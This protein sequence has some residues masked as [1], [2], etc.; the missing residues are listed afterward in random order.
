MVC[1]VAIGLVT[2]CEGFAMI[3]E[4]LDMRTPATDH[5]FHLSPEVSIHIYKIP[6]GNLGRV[7]EKVARLNKRALK[8]GLVPIVLN[9]HG[10]EEKVTRHEITGAERRT[11]L[12]LL[13]IQGETPTLAGW[14]FL[15]TLQH[16][17]DDQGAPMNLVRAVPGSEGL[18]NDYRAVAQKCDHCQVS[19]RRIDTYVVRHAESGDIK[20][21]GSSC[22]VDFIGTEDPTTVLARFTYLLSLAGILESE[23]S[24]SSGDRRD[25]S[26]SLED[27]LGCVCACAREHGFTTRK[28]A[29]DSQGKV[30]TASQAMSVLFPAP[31][32]TN[33]RCYCGN[34]DP[35][36]VQVSAD[37]QA[38]A[39][40][41]LAWARETL[42][43]R[44]QLND[45]L[46]NLSVVSSLESIDHKSAGI[47]ASLI[48]C[49]AREMEKAIIAKRERVTQA[50]SQYVGQVKDKVTLTAQLIGLRSF[51]TRYGDCHMHRFL[52]GSGNVLT[53]FA[54]KSQH[55]QVGSTYKVIGTVKK[56]E[57]YQGIKQTV[58]TRVKLEVIEVNQ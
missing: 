55:A 29:R 13:S 52:D 41:A 43:D 49:Y 33:E 3:E 47:A 8:L 46:Y 34:R 23:E 19:R 36:H 51:E 24:Y 40:A 9:S 22:L 56:H 44:N 7:N 53:W 12:H 45:Y 5:T 10:I 37:D 25:Y 32:T 14:Q 58:L 26:F 57:S 39:L 21:V 6:A 17:T 4:C 27:Y 54:S 15:A 30:A 50:N 28:E 1:G 18:L 16:L 35:R 11:T 42:T 2:D 38:N 31:K 48:P 20:Q